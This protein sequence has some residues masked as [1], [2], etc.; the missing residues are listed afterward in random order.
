MTVEVSL[1]LSGVSVAFAIYL[2]MARQNR[3]K[4]AINKSEASAMATVV[5]KLET[6]EGGI[7]EIKQEISCIK[8]DFQADHDRLIRLESTRPKPRQPS[9]ADSAMQGG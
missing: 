2:G 6:I 7:G 8:R 3:E 1:L 4:E 5:Y 9:T